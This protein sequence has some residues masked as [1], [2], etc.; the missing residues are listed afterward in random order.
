MYQGTINERE[1]GDFPFSS[2]RVGLEYHSKKEMFFFKKKLIIIQSGCF[3]NSIY[4][5]C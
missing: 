2:C 3:R 4:I 1:P 5:E